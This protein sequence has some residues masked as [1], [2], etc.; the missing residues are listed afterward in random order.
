MC[1]HHFKHSNEVLLCT[2]YHLLRDHL[3]PSKGLKGFIV[4]TIGMHLQN[5]VVIRWYG[6]MDSPIPT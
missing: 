4:I 5:F 3:T 2:A 6:F 1:L